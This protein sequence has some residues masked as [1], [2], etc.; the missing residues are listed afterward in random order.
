[1]ELAAKGLFRTKWTNEIHEEWITALLHNRPEL[2][3]AKLERTRDLMNTHVLDC[4][5]IDYE[6]LIPSISCP[7]PNDRHVIA[8]AIKGN[9]A[10]IITFNLNHFPASELQKYDIEAQHPDEFL[11]HQ[12]GL[13][14]AAVIVAARNIRLRLKNPPVSAEDY[15]RRLETQ[16]LPKTVAELSHYST[17]I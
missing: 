3:R 16:S 5:V 11:H 1:V 12:F 9:C 17:V 7:D 6:D 2:Q 4:L 13:D 14:K 10:A 8:A 15:L